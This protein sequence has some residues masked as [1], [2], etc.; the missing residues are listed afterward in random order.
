MAS[1]IEIPPPRKEIL[2]HSVGML[3]DGQPNGLPENMMPLR[4]TVGGGGIKHFN[5]SVGAAIV[6]FP[7]PSSFR[8]A[9]EMLYV[10]KLRLNVPD[11]QI[12]TD[13]RQV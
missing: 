2:H 3:T 1:F 8:S 4:P 11:F 7:P 9:T 5:M 12:T 10:Q 6:S 13:T